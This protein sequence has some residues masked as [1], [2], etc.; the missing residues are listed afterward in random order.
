MEGSDNQS[1]EVMFA[2]INCFSDKKEF[3]LQNKKLYIYMTGQ[4]ARP[5]GPT[6]RRLTTNQEI[7]GSN[8]GQ[9]SHMLVYVHRCA[10]LLRLKY[11]QN[12]ATNVSTIFLFSVM[13]SF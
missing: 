5:V 12:L 13:T 1:G 4:I 6:V 11:L 3:R 8:P 7:P 9:V 10:V 2:F